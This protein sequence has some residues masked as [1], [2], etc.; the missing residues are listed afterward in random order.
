MQLENKVAIVTGSARGI[1][2]EIA[3]HFVS[4]GAKV[5]ISDIAEDTLL[6]AKDELKKIGGNVDFC[7][8]D[9]TNADDVSNLIKSTVEKFGKLD[10]LVNNAGITKDG[11]LMRMKEN[12]WDMVL[13]IN[14]KGA[15]NC[16]KVA[17]RQIMK[18]KGSIINIASIVGLMGNAGQCNYS[19]SK[20]GLIGFTKSLAI[21]VGKKEARVNAIAPGF[22]KTAMTDGLSEDVKNK[23][24]ENI[25]MGR[26]GLPEEIAKTAVFLAS[27]NS[28][29]ITGQV[30]SVNGGMYR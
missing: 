24:F 11:L 17:L 6:I 8:A 15:F 9:V 1:G 7:K 26:F 13:N 10:I 20:A 4:E 28:T 19:A 21:E 5:M 18:N 22:I 29:Y 27:D 3:K 16:S 25:P 30:I 2:Y 23:M 12:D 14:L